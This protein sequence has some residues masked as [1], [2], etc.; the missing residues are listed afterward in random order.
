M[1]EQPI[2]RRKFRFPVIDDDEFV[3]RHDEE[4]AR[5]IFPENDF[6]TSYIGGDRPAPQQIRGNQR[7]AGFDQV[8]RAEEKK[9]EK[10][11]D[12]NILTNKTV[13]FDEE[14]ELYNEKKFMKMGNIKGKQEKTPNDDVRKRPMTSESPKYKTE[15]KIEAPKLRAFE[16]KRMKEHAQNPEQRVSQYRREIEKE[17][18]QTLKQQYSGGLNRFRPR[19]DKNLPP[20][21]KREEVSESAFTKSEL[22]DSMKKSA[23]SMLLFEL[24]TK[25]TQEEVAQKTKTW[26]ENAPRVTARQAKP[27][28]TSSNK[29][30]TKSVDAQKITEDQPIYNGKPNVK[31]EAQ[32]AT[33]ATPVNKKA[34]VK[35][36]GQKQKRRA[37][38]RDLSGIMDS[39]KKSMGKIE[40]RL[41]ES[42]SE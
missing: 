10:P 30:T 21:M 14:R 35:Q 29:H 24:D 23:D 32:T 27:I 17:R 16:K 25:E 8:P 26:H 36:P 33:T 31:V 38:G 19:A 13:E 11:L 4:E 22:V 2:S 5:V 12:I 41:F 28:I 42:G 40:N 15:Q 1:T 34:Q 18:H 37:L 6:L 3:T 39:E 7:F 9:A 20:Q